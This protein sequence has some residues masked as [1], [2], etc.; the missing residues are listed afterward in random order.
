M[1][2]TCVLLI[3]A[4]VA[5]PPAGDAVKDAQAKLKGT[6]NSTEVVKGGEKSDKSLT[7]KFDGDKVTVAIG[8]EDE[9]SAKYTVDPSKSPATLDVTIEHDGQT[10]TAEALYELKGDVLRLCH[11]VDVLG[12][13]RP[14]AI[15]ATATTSVVTLKRSK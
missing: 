11:A 5:F 2:S 8:G 6:W 13:T 14:T 12:G 9:I 10:I 4:V 1:K 7:L 3:A 15:E